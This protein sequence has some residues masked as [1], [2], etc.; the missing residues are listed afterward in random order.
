MSSFEEE[1]LWFEQVI[2]SIAWIENQSPNSWYCRSQ[3]FLS[4]V[5]FDGWTY[6][7][8]ITQN[9]IQQIKNIEPNFDFQNANAWLKESEITDCLLGENL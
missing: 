6:W 8:H 2:H 1:S 9:Y 5:F 7:H 4:P 3:Q